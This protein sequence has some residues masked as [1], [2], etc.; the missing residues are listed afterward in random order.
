MLKCALLGDFGS[1]KSSLYQR[2]VRGTYTDDE[3]DGEDYDFEKIDVTVD[4]RVATVQLWDTA[5][6]EEHSAIE[7]S[8][9]RGLLGFLLVFD[10]SNLKSFQRIEYWRKQ[11]DVFAADGV[12]LVL[13]GHKC[14]IPGKH[15]VVDEYQG[16]TL[17]AKL[18]CPYLE[19]SAKSNTNVQ[20]ALQTLVR[21]ILASN[22]A[23]GIE[24]RSAAPAA[25]EASNQGVM[26]AI[27]LSAPMPGQRGKNGKV[28]GGSGKQKGGCC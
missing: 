25:S 28:A 12:Q 26:A 9:F 20:E 16:K 24:T 6:M 22:N 5:G 23:K 21:N 11:V 17:S 10:V 13:V 1:G 14:D 7:G 27:D 8:Y 2:L 4:G 3:D 19:V 15:R 18:N